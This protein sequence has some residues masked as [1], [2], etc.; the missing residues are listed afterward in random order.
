MDRYYRRDG[1]FLLR[2]ARAHP[3]EAPSRWPD[4]AA[5]SVDDLCTWVRQV[6]HGPIAAAIADAS[7]SLATTLGN[8]SDGTP[9][10]A[11]VRRAAT[12]LVGYLLRA[13]G[14]AT[15]F[16]LFAGT[17]PGTFAPCGKIR[18][19]HDHHTLVRPDAA[20]LEAVVAELEAVPAVVERLDVVANNRHRQ[21]G[22]YLVLADG[23]SRI[24]LAATAPVLTALHAAAAPT[25]S[26]TVAERVRSAFPAASDH[27]VADLLSGLLAHGFLLS[28]LRPPST[29][30]D[31]LIHL[32]DE[33]V[34]CRADEIGDAAAAAARVHAAAASPSVSPEDTGP[35]AVTRDLRLD[36]DVAVP[37]RV[38]AAVE[39]GVTALLR[40]SP[41]PTGSPAWRRYYEAFVH[42]YGAA[43]LVPLLDAVDADM[44]VGYPPT[45]PG[46]LMPPRPDEPPQRDS[47]LL[48]LAQEAAATG[49]EEVVL[50][51]AAIDRLAVAPLDPQR[52]PAHVEAAVRVRARSME[53]IESGDFTLRIRPGQAAGTFT[54]R[55]SPWESDLA[56]LYRRLPPATAGAVR[57]QL[58]FPARRPSA[59]NVARTPRFL[60]DLVCLGEYPPEDDGLIRVE[61]LAVMADRDRLHLVHTP[62]RRLVEPQ[63]VH[64]LSLEHQ[65]PPLARFLAQLPRGCLAQFDRV[66]WGAAADLAFLPRLRYGHTVLSPARWRLE[67]DDLPPHGAT[68]TEW[69]AG[70]ERWCARWRVPRQVELAQGDQVLPLDLQEPAHTA[71]L[72]RRLHQAGHVLLTEAEPDDARGWIQGRAHE[73]AVPLVTATPPAPSPLGRTLVKTRDRDR[74]HLPADDDADW[75][76]AKIYAHPERQNAILPQHLPALLAE[77]GEPDWWFLRYRGPDDPDHLRLRLRVA[78]GAHAGQ[79]AAALGAWTRG[80]RRAG[81]SPRMSLDT[82]YPETGR[83]GQGTTLEAAEAVFVADSAAVVDRLR[84][85]AGEGCPDAAATMAAMAAA[86]TGGWPAGLDWLIDQPAPAPARPPQRELQTATRALVDSGHGLLTD[87]LHRALTHYGSLLR[88]G[89]GPPTDTVLTSLLHMHHIRA[90]GVD[91]D[92]E[93]TCRRLAR[94]AA[95]SQTARTREAA[96]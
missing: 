55:F 21:R 30:P 79:V 87:E 26:A 17:A 5:D 96:S 9:P 48:Q 67:S 33:L 45:F 82:Y 38:G 42:R 23:Q 25:S 46:S 74:G 75:L 11:K 15:P 20:W 49:T 61:D 58:V 31:P 91:R 94:H 4:L 71:L 95:L 76:Y 66:A 56:A 69:R 10:E 92:S 90:L 53:A 24:E 84:T 89:G 2:A 32:R 70:L 57:A 34:R 44:G 59:D 3:G 14:R 7:P 16:G 81:L 77:T 22:D 63:V 6:W 64:A 62:T 28:S 85:G 73:L 47:R 8:I 93:R 35:A 88:A 27:H 54:G 72:R 52:I 40:L 68:P 80:L 86:F 13:T 78:D 12:A 18:W 83:Y 50:D 39:A 37:E 19:G 1:P 60:D 51:D 43:V 41:H 65:A 29:A 36:C